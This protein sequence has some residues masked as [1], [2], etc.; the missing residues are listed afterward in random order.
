MHI[1]TDTLLILAD[2]DTTRTSQSFLENFLRLAKLSQTLGFSWFIPG[3]VQ[4][5]HALLILLVHLDACPCTNEEHILTRDLIDQAFNLRLGRLLE[6]SNTSISFTPARINGHQQ[7]NSRYIALTRLKTRVWQKL[8]CSTSSP[9]NHGD[10]VEE[11]PRA[12][13]SPDSGALQTSCSVK[14]NYDYPLQEDSLS[15]LWNE[16]SADVPPDIG[17]ISNW[18]EWNSLSAGFFAD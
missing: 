14:P 17:G 7:H 18:D 3:L 6:G 4:P 2:D 10:M 1:A 5:L 8:S 9:H 11:R 16:F 13:K 15:V 12:M